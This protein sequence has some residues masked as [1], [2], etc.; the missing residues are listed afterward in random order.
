MRNL[1]TRQTRK[2][3]APA[4]MA[5]PG[6]MALL[7]LGAAVVLLPAA[8][9]AVSLK[10][11]SVIESNVITLGDVFSGLDAKAGRVLGPA[12]RPGHDMTLNARTL[13][14]I[15]VAMDL[16]W[17]PASTGEY[18]VLSRA[19]TVIPSAMIREALED[20]L[21]TQGVGGRF[22]V[23]IVSGARELVLPHSETPGVAVESLS[24]NAA[25]NRFEA[26]LAAPG[27]ANPLVREKISG[28][29]QR[30]TALPV[31]GRVI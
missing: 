17:R 14:R 28:A 10:H 5:G 15:A 23:A 19:A 4:R 18:V 31:L 20:E 2:R 13:M 24:F 26:V 27:A 8:A 1:M 11:N 30:L 7:A 6:R 21:R 3:P 22:K 9:S 25:Q 12:P 29:V 16:P